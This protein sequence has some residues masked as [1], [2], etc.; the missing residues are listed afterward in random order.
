MNTIC[1]NCRGLGTFRAVHAVAKLVK[2]FN[3]QLLF[4]SETKKSSEMEWLRSRWKFDH[5][6]AVDSLG[7]AGGLALL[8]MKDVSVE[9][10]SYFNNHIDVMME[11]GIAKR[12]RFTGFY[13]NPIANQKRE[14]WALL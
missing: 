3:P 4:L 2:K 6:F 7:R 14:S 11:G 13:G 5:C 9:V 12:C 1:W 8:W 10:K